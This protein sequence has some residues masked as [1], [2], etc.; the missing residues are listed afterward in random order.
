MPVRKTAAA[1]DGGAVPAPGGSV[2]A[3]DPADAAADAA[4]PAGGS[5]PSDGA[6]SG[7]ADPVDPAD[8]P[9]ASSGGTPDRARLSSA[10]VGEAAQAP[11]GTP[12]GEAADPGPPA[13][14]DA[15]GTTSRGR[16]ATAAKAAAVA[17]SGRPEGLAPLP[18]RVPQTSLAAEL[19]EETVSLEE[20][21]FPDDFTAERA[22]SSLAGFQRGTLQARDDDVPASGS[23]EAVAARPAGPP[24]TAAGASPTP[25]P[26]ADRS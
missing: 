25:T 10:A 26:P 20:D 24:V 18:R 22:A 2:P 14:D 5:D 23:D 7:T 9:S 8:G 16:G 21:G 6:A 19:R 12:P 15:A 13:P 17:V 4:D 11:A 3:H 1:A